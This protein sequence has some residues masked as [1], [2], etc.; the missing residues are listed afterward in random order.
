[1]KAKFDLKEFIPLGFLSLVGIA[2]AI[3]VATTDY[4]FEP[5]A[6]V[7]LTLL[8]VCFILFFLNASWYRYSMAFILIIG[9]F[10]LIGFSTVNIS[11]GIGILQF[12]IIPFVALILF[13][14]VYNSRIPAA[15]HR[16]LGMDKTEEENLEGFNARKAGF[17]R[18]F[19]KLPDSEIDRRLKTK[20]VPE[21]IQALEELKEERNNTLQHQL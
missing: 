8:V 13:S 21:A 20:L 5:Q 4:I 10:G 6:Y 15:I 9:T 19:E 7:G 16:L 3:Q 14:S 12:H 11:F 2:S 17:K 18:T 1:M